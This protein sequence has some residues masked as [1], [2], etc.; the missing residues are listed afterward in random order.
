MMVGLIGFA[1]LA[2]LVLRFLP[3]ARNPLVMPVTADAPVFHYARNRSF[4]FSRDWDLHLVNT[5]RVNNAG[6]VNDQDYR[7]EEKTPLLGVIG[8]SYIEAFMVP[9]PATLQGR[10]A[11]ALQDRIRVYSFAASGAP[12]S[13]YLIWGRQ[14]VREYG[15]NALIVNVVGNDFDESHDAFKRDFPGFW[16]YV[17][18]ADGALRLR[19]F[20][21]HVGAMRALVKHSALARYLFIN[22]HLK[23][24]LSH[25]NWLRTPKAGGTPADRPP[26]AGNTS[27]DTSTARINA[28][29][30]VID[31]FFRDLP[32]VVGLSPERILFVIDGFRYPADAR[33]GA[34]TYFE[35]MR[36]AFREKAEA[37]GYEVI[38]VDPLFFADFRKHARPF[39]DSRDRHW[40][41]T[42]HGIVADAVLRSKAGSVPIPGESAVARPF[43]AKAGSGGPSTS[44][45]QASSHSSHRTVGPG[46]TPAGRTGSSCT[47]P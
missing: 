47:C 9:Y 31:A 12:L 33:D 34:G 35:R 14:A 20:E 18:N 15:A 6:M 38:D 26:Y 37:S 28:S 43:A 23:A 2:E 36:H 22:L 32:E 44:R 21:F 24:V 39:E 5:G 30:Q 42:A 4:L 10:L 7:R 41:A 16:I 29:I 25:W 45:M 19:L 46:R 40:N 1:I 11:K 3:V 13:Q 17:P 27:A 8:D